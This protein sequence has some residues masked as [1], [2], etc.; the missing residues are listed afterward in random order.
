MQIRWTLEDERRKWRHARGRVS[1]ELARVVKRWKS[2]ISGRLR[3][4][5]AAESPSY[6]RIARISSSFSAT[7]ARACMLTGLPNLEIRYAPG[8]WLS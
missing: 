7:Q 3:I 4:N 8:S 6:G 2:T 1:H 5:E